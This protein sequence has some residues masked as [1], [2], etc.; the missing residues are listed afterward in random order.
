MIALLNTN[1]GNFAAACSLD[2]SKPPLYY[3]TFALR[4]S[5]GHET[6]SQT[7]PYFRSAKSRRA[8][9]YGV[10]VPVS[11]CWNGIGL[12]TPSPPSTTSDIQ[13]EWSNLGIVA[14]PT[15]AF[16]GS[17][18]LKFRGV[19]DSL[20]QSHLEGSECCLIHADNPASKTRGVFLNPTVRVGYNEEAY[21]KVH[22]EGSNQVWLSTFGVYTGIWKS[23]LAR[24]LSSPLLKEQVVRRRVR[25]WEAEGAEGETREEPG[26]FCLINEMQ[27]IVENGWKHL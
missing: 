25:K 22:P 15:S 13:A 19:P 26:E 6:A 14:M 12:S 3:D 27:V 21:K 16:T 5:A 1:R 20:A 23:R 17:N 7:W 11:S 8:M 24:W 2:F 10:P 9:L 18:G 4:D